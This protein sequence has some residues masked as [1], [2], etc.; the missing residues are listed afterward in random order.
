MSNMMVCDH[1][2]T[3]VHRE[4]AKRTYVEKYGA[5][6]AGQTIGICPECGD[7]IIDRDYY[8]RMQ[9]EKDN[10]EKQ[11]LADKLS[12]AIGVSN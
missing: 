5:S 10:V 11:G 7:Y 6:P 3:R 4:H 8:G 9:R 1:C 2:D 12:A